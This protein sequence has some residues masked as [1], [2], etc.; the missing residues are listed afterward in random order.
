MAG[1][2]SLFAGLDVHQDTIAVAH[3]SPPTR[4]SRAWSWPRPSSP[5]SLARQKT[6]R[7]DRD[8]VGG[9]ALQLT[10]EVLSTCV[11]SAAAA[12]QLSAGS[13][14]VPLQLRAV[15]HRSNATDTTLSALV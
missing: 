9:G 1:P 15:A 13:H 3:A 10:Q 11:A 8:R 14:C 6:D 7:R 5:R 4:E 2:V 12:W